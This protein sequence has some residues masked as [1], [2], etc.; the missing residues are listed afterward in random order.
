MYSLLKI[1]I[2]LILKFDLIISVEHKLVLCE[3]EPEQLQ[4]DELEAGA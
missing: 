1:S 3:L 2:H 4:Y